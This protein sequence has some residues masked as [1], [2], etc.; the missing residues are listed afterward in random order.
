[1]RRFALFFVTFA[2]GL[3]LGLAA[4]PTA[5][6][7][8]EVSVVFLGDPPAGLP[9]RVDLT[10]YRDAARPEGRPDRPGLVWR[11]VVTDSR[12]KASEFYAR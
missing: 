3:L 4:R 10:V 7:P 8:R 2:A 12:G 9:P 11:F 6:P 5:A 1:M